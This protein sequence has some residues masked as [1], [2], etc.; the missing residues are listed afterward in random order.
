MPDLPI[1]R[2]R[3]SIPLWAVLLGFSVRA[4]GRFLSFLLRH[5]VAVVLLVGVLAVRARYG[6]QTLAAAG[7]ALAML[8]LAWRWAHRRSFAWLARRLRARWRLL[9]VYRL[10][11]RNVMVQ[12]GLAIR[13]PLSNGERVRFAEYFP[14]IRKIRSSR[15]GDALRIELL[16]GQ[17]PAT[18]ADQADGLAHAF[19]ARECRVRAAGPGF[20]WVAFTL[21]DPLTDT[22]PATDQDDDVDAWDD[23]EGGGSAA[24]DLDSLP[25]GR[26]QDGQPWRLGL[27]GTHT[28]VAGATGS[29]KGSV[30]WST[31][32]R[33]A[34]R[35]APAWSS[36]GS[37]TP[38]AA[39]NSPLAG[40]CSP[41]LPSTCPLS[42]L[43]STMRSSPCGNGPTGHG[44]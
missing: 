12:T 2:R 10:R 30:V 13:M 34:Q 28:L 5:P 24:V 21:A 18:W 31:I 19:R 9:V 41:G 3:P 7:F 17:T 20:V 33:S 4:V 26:Q 8:G 1:D 43:S 32:A 6:W 36:C 29:G 39:W 42:P 44:V 37:A 40:R 23:Y 11:W 25:V 16:Y 35:S 27:R 38:R 15:W 22:I 14:R